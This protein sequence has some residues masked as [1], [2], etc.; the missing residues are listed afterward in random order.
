MLSL[1]SSPTST[2]E[3]AN[4]VGRPRGRDGHLFSTVGA[5]SSHQIDRIVFV[6]SLR[7]DSGKTQARGSPVPPTE[8]TGLLSRRSTGIIVSNPQRTFLMWYHC[9]QPVS[10]HEMGSHHG[11]MGWQLCFLPSGRLFRRPRRPLAPSGRRG[12]ASRWN[13]SPSPSLVSKG[14]VF[15]I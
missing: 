6:S 8:F 5:G 7:E 1:S 11:M 15:K 10:H 13:G 9:K 2:K 12:E 4:L 3:P 14:L